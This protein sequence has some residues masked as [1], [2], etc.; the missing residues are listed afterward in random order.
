MRADRVP[1]KAV[2]TVL[3]G[4]CLCKTARMLINGVTDKFCV[5][6]QTRE[7]EVLCYPNNKS[8][9]AKDLKKIIEL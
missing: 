9:I 6:I 1:C 4:V 3:T 5:D 2:L 8:W 7:R